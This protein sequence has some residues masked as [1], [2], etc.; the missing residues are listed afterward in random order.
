M[1]G[2]SNDFGIGEFMCVFFGNYFFEFGLGVR[3][4]GSL[5]F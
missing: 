5:R 1:K 3:D 2:K 4:S